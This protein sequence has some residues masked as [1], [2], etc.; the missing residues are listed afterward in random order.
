[1]MSSINKDIRKRRS[2]SLGDTLLTK[3]RIKSSLSQIPKGC[4]KSPSKSMIAEDV[5]VKGKKE[6][7]PLDEEVFEKNSK[8][9][10]TESKKS[11]YIEDDGSEF[12][13]IYNNE[14][15]L[16]LQD[17]NSIP[18]LNYK[19]NYIDQHGII[20]FDSDSDRQNS[21]LSSESHLLNNENREEIITKI[22]DSIASKNE[23]L[24]INNSLTSS[25][26]NKNFK[27]K[28]DFNTPIA[29]TNHNNKVNENKNTDNKTLKNIRNLEEFNNDKIKNDINKSEIKNS[30]TEIDKNETNIN[31]IEKANN[32]GENENSSENK[33]DISGIIVGIDNSEKEQEEKMENEIISNQGFDDNNLIQDF[34]DNLNSEEE[35][36]AT[37]E[38]T[39]PFTNS[40]NNEENDKTNYND[41]I[42]KANKF[43]NT[44]T[45]SQI[46]NFNNMTIKDKEFKLFKENQN[47]TQTNIFDDLPIHD[48]T[49]HTEIMDID[50][51]LPNNNNITEIKNNN[52]ELNKNKKKFNN[53]KLFMK[54]QSLKSLLNEKDQNSSIN[55]EEI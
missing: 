35:F 1:M 52:I 25:L 13:F 28:N 41:N 5:R 7:G 15:P 42:D 8:F 29:I 47:I 2:K 26:F 22:M 32:E 31:I 39:Q 44:E 24:E 6:E 30:N 36:T 40:V 17:L 16:K 21:N 14:S 11:S 54:D 38:L 49:L 10:S 55:N 12:R 27:E 43:I 51:S 19:E 45:N 46:I 50:L 20:N 18:K 33:G 23:K 48:E 9:N 34:N 3:K 53:I 37:M 4:L